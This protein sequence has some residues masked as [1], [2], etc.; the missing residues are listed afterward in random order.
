M[1]YKELSVM[2][3]DDPSSQTRWEILY[4]PSSHV[5]KA[6]GRLTDT[7]ESSEGC[8][9]RY[10]SKLTRSRIKLFTLTFSQ[11]ALYMKL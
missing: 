7:R 5:R 2:D 6:Q 10:N 4:L 1:L 11:G 9:P 3:D 8:S